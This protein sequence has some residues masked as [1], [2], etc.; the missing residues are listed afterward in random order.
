MIPYMGEN[1]EKIKRYDLLLKVRPSKLILLREIDKDRYLIAIARDLPQNAWVAFETNVDKIYVNIKN[2]YSIDKCCCK[3]ALVQ[4]P[5]HIYV[6]NEI[7]KMH[8]KWLQELIKKQKANYKLK[9]NKRKL[10]RIEPVSNIKKHVAQE[11]PTHMQWAA[12]HPYQG[13]DFSGK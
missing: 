12:K 3:K 9:A 10:I 11:I 5:N 4:F 6:V 8:N 7:Y 2:F 1:L 13:G